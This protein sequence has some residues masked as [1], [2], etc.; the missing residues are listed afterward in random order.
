MARELW[1]AKI[2]E[3]NVASQLYQFIPRV[4]DGIEAEGA[5]VWADGE[6]HYWNTPAA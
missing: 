5:L 1:L 3:M 6:A 4:Q 2:A